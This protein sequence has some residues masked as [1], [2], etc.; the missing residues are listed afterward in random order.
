MLYQFPVYWDDISAYTAN[1]SLTEITIT[2]DIALYGGPFKC[3]VVGF[4]YADNLANAVA[5]DNQDIVQIRSSK[6][7]FPLFSRQGLLFTNREEHVHPG[8]KGH[9]EFV[10]DNIGGDIDLTISVKQFNVNRTANTAATWN[11]TGFIALILSLDIE[12]MSPDERV[13]V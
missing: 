13:R 10:I 2:R 12:P 5:A 8:M 11:D 9:Y 7:V 6:F 3:R 4:T 1:T